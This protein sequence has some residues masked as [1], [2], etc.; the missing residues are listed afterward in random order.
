MGIP[1]FSDPDACP[2]RRSLPVAVLLAEGG[3]DGVSLCKALCD[4]RLEFFFTLTPEELLARIARRPVRAVLIVG[5]EALGRSRELEQTLTRY[6]PKTLLAELTRSPAGHPTLNPLNQPPQ[7]PQPPPPP[8][9][10]SPPPPPE[11]PPESPPPA[12]H[13]DDDA[14]LT[15]DEL[16]MLLGG[17]WD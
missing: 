5:R 8:P 10:L 4:R 3:G 16:A 2:A 7:P 15:H 17:D 1:A 12:L 14:R 13:H 11:M 9:E 6:Y